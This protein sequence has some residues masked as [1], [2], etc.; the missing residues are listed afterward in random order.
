VKVQGA[1]AAIDVPVIIGET[2]ESTEGPRVE[3]LSG[4]NPGDRVLVP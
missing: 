2:F 3:I 4:L 1:A